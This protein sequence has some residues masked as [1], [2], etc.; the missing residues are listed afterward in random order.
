MRFTEQNLTSLKNA[1]YFILE[2]DP[3]H[4][5]DK[6]IK[7]LQNLYHKIIPIKGWH[8]SDIIAVCLGIY[9]SRN[10]NES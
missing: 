8:Q 2:N 3:D 9:F 7:D 6:V 10:S 5:K 4:E 1:G